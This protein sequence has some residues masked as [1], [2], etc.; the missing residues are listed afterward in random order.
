MRIMAQKNGTPSA[1]TRQ[2]EVITGENATA[3]LVE[4]AKKAKEA[5]ALIEQELAAEKADGE[6]EYDVLSES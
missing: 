6:G 3:V 2:R 5:V 1:W 4:N